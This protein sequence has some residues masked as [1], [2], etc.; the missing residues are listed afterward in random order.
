[1]KKRKLGQ[2]GL[3]VSAL[4]L[5]CMGMSYGYGPA[6]HLRNHGFLLQPNAWVLS[7]AYDINP[8]IYLDALK[9][10][11][12]ESDNTQSLELVKSVA[13]Y[14]RISQN[15][16]NELITDMIRILRG[17]QKKHPNWV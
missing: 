14:F 15:R 3:E 13:P 5:G 11:I 12:S 2:Q 6:D 9:L 10:N 8:L 1:M 4:G 7:P 17:W 16:A